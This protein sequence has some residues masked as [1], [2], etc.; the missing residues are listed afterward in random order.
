MTILDDRTFDFTSSSAAQ[1]ERLGVRLGETVAVAL[2]GYM[3]AGNLGALGAGSSGADPAGRMPGG[4]SRKPAP[5]AW[6]N[7]PASRAEQTTP[8]RPA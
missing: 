7:S 1:T 5:Q 8:S 4:T 3:L 6:R 2:G